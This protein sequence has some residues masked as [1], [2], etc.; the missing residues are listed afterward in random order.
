MLYITIINTNVI[1]IYLT[2]N[3]SQNLKQFVYEIIHKY[4]LQP[5]ETQKFIYTG[6]EINVWNALVELAPEAD[7]IR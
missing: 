3:A 5:Y 4:D 2:Q 7:E 1:Q 6:F